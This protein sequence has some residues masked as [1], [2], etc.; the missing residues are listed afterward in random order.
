MATFRV[1]IEADEKS[2]PVLLS[3]GNLLEQGK[4]ADGRHFAVWDDPFPKPC[5]LF[6]LVAGD[7]VHIEDHFTTKS[8]LDVALRIYV[9]AG[10]EGQCGYA[11]DSLKRSMKW[12]EDVYGREYQYGQFQHRRGVGLQHGRDG[13]HVAQ[14]LQHGAGAG[15]ARRPR[16]IAI[17]SIVEA[18]IA[19]EYFHNWTGNRVT[20]RDWFQL[21]LKEG[22]TVF[23]D[24]EFSAPI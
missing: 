20:C 6:A 18:V 2:C 11:M 19:H 13:E 4:L 24:Q 1:R 9:R 16:P 22:L 21:S 10:D 12:D 7:L 8:G 23:R 3:N 17:T 15:A 14:H 5:Y